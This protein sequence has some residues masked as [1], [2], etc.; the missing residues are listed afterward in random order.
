MSLLGEKNY[1]LVA[2]ESGHQRAG[3]YYLIIVLFICGVVC[4]YPL[5]SPSVSLSTIRD[6]VDVSCYLGIRGLPLLKM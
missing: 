2:V 6:A 4:G 3:T 5:W 1:V